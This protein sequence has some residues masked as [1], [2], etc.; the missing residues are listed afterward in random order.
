MSQPRGSASSK[1]SVLLIDEKER[2]SRSSTLIRG[3]LVLSAVLFYFSYIRG[4][5]LSP[6]ERPQTSS[7]L[8]QHRFDP[9]HVLEADEKRGRSEFDVNS[10]IL[11]SFTYEPL[12]LSPPP[13]LFPSLLLEGNENRADFFGLAP[14]RRSKR[15][16][17]AFNI[18]SVSERWVLLM[19]E[20]NWAPQTRGS[21]ILLVTSFFMERVPMEKKSSL[22]KIA[23]WG[24]ERLRAAFNTVSRTIDFI[25]GR[26]KRAECRILGFSFSLR[27]KSHFLEQTEAA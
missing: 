15:L 16:R 5:G 24:D 17:I 19:D 13:P 18:V 12:S 3:S 22:W 21:L 1:L 4:R 11:G 26:K 14:S 25:N 27:P 7:N 23:T 6:P 10:V 8:S 2:A 9:N 20:K